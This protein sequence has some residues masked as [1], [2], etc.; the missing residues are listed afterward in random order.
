MK[1]TQRGLPN[2]SLLY[3]RREQE[4]VTLGLKKKKS[5]LLQS[6]FPLVNGRIY[7]ADYLTNADQACLTGFRFHFQETKP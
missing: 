7:Q 3:R 5:E 2:E 6:Y 1:E 4:K